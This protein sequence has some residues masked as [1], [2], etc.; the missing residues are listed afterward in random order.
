MRF[1]EEIK[2]DLIKRLE[3][4]LAMAKKK[5]TLSY[6]V[7]PAYVIETPREKEHGDFAT[8]LA[9]AMAK[10]ARMAPRKIAETILSEL[11]ITGSYIAKTEVAGAGFINFF[12][13]HDWLYRVPAVVH[14]MGEK[15]G[16]AELGKGMKVQVEFVSANPTGL[17]HMGNA[18]GGAI[19]DSLGNLLQFAGYDVEKEFYINDA[20]NQ[21]RLLGKSL[22]ARFLQL[23][24]EDVLFPEE[25]Y[26][27][28]DIIETVK[29]Y[30]AEHGDELRGKSQEEREETLSKYALKEKLAAIQNVMAMYGVHFDVWFSEQSL[31]DSGKV[32]AAVDYLLEKGYAYR[33]EDGSI[34][35]KA[36][37]REESGKKKPSKNGEHVNLE[38]KDDVLVRA[39]GIPTYFAADIAYHRD[40]FDR[41]F[42]R[43][44]N[45]WGADHHG[46]VARMKR[47]VSLFGYD[48]QSLTVIL[49]QLVKLYRNGELVRMSK[50][51]GQYVTLEDLV[52][53]VG[54][55][56]A[57]YFFVMRN[58]D[59]AMDFD[60]DLAKSQSSDNPVFYVQYAHAR[61]C[62]ILRQ[63]EAQGY[64][65]PDFQTVDYG[66]LIENQE[67]ALL[68]K[69]ADLPEEIASAAQTLEPHRLCTYLHDLASTFHSF[70]NHCRVNTDDE[71]LRNAR[72]GLSK[73]TAI[74]IKNVLTILGVH[75]PNEM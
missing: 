2:Q 27:G 24:G 52:E 72:L 11:D 6:E 73:A 45:I 4:A 3:A 71:K 69:L 44:I 23:M 7:L 42:D 37:H 49:M 38:D 28:D 63:A 10:E 17:L 53:E 41:G 31:H 62:S 56:A 36:E 26:H 12:L 34:L 64:Q 59:S 58:P 48:P 21:I 54:Y 13:N 5:G 46:H 18:R 68:K 61:I 75:A 55:D 74:A 70:Y 22:D 65:L 30:R 39:N 32:Q 29:H 60:L 8:N 16:S 51:S 25:G 15:F 47:A 14:E 1:I 33:G 67:L 43:V 40:K 20:G 9:M 19:G 50:R 57:R 35:L 66:V